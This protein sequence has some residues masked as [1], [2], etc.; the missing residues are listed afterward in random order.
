MEGGAD[1]NRPNLPICY[2]VEPPMKKK[3][4][5]VLALTA[6]IGVLAIQ[7][8][9]QETTEGLYFAQVRA[10]VQANCV[11]CHTQGGSGMPVILTT[12]ADIVSHAASI[13]STTSDPVSPTNK[14][15]PTTGELSEADKTVIINWL[16]AGGT[17]ND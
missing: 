16:A 4:M 1:T 15:M 6:M 12:D 5:T 11:S 7:A 2:C 10:I 17:V 13:K 9:K 14:R 8:C 3:S